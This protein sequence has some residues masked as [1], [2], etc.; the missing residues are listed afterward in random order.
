MKN[1]FFQPRKNAKMA[2]IAIFVAIVTFVMMAVSCSS[3]VKN[4]L[5]GVDGKNGKDGINGTDGK[6]GLNGTDGKD[7]AVTSVTLD[8][9]K[10]TLDGKSTS[11]DGETLSAPINL[12]ANYTAGGE[13]SGGGRYPLN[14]AVLISAKQNYGYNFLCWKNEKDEIVAENPCFLTSATEVE[15][16]YTAIFEIDKSKTAI[17]VS[18]RADKSLPNGVTVEGGGRFAYGSEYTLSVVSE[19][20]SILNSGTVFFYEVT[21]EQFDDENYVVLKKAEACSRGRIARFDV[22]GLTDKYYVVAY[23]DEMY[24]DVSYNIRVEASCEIE[25]KSSNDFYGKPA[26]TKINGKTPE[27]DSFEILQP[28]WAGDEVTV[29]ANISISPMYDDNYDEFYVRYMTVNR[30]S[31]VGW[32]DELTGETVSESLEY[33]FVV[34]RDVSLIAIFKPKTVLHF[35]AHGITLALFT[36][37]VVIYNSRDYSYCGAIESFYPGEEIL[38]YAYFLPPISV[39]TLQRLNKFVWQ[40]SYDNVKWKTL[41]YSRQ[42][43]IKIPEN[44]HTV[45]IKA[46][47]DLK[48][49]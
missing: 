46:T 31:F 6:N 23:I 37:D 47:L 19:N 5:N 44:V 35:E 30:A 9:G 25:V 33:T 14:T 16:N 49:S 32:I 24:I 2:F 28:I 17:N 29:T 8:D 21:K 20:E 7:G 27:T 43:Y 39:V 4:G 10:V 34:K 13:I 15:Q 12:S 3:S 36:K 48:S 40:I 22:D 38:V 11:Y 1:G 18:V 42:A 26:I 41:S 45:Y